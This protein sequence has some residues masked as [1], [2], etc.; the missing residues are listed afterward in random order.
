MGRRCN[1]LMRTI[2]AMVSRMFVHYMRN[3]FDDRLEVIFPTER[4]VRIM[5]FFMLNYRDESGR[6]WPAIE[7]ERRFLI[8]AANLGCSFT[9]LRFRSD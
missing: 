4:N 9:R 6:S 1:A 5:N 8:C 7:A 3:R 2:I